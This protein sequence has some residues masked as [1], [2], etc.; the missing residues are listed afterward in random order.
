MA[1]A[2]P[3]DM[4]LPIA[5]GLTWPERLADAAPGIDWSVPQ[6]WTFE[7]LDEDVFPAI[8]VARAAMAASALHPAVFN[9]AN[10]ECVAAFA[11]GRLPFLSIVDTVADVLAAF[12]APQ[13]VSLDTVADAER[14]ARSSAQAAI[15]SAT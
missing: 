3:P 14:W 11:G 8:R 6:T 15:A 4:R 1:Q 2:S 7:P 10:E 12:E 13:E 5:L 9:A